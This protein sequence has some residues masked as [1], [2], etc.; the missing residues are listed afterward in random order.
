MTQNA[1]R[2]D[3]PVRNFDGAGCAGCGVE[4]SRKWLYT[5]K[6]RGHLCV[7]IFEALQS[8]VGPVPPQFRSWFCMGKEKK[9]ACRTQQEKSKTMVN[10]WD[11]GELPTYS[12]VRVAGAAI[13]GPMDGAGMTVM[14]QHD[15]FAA[16]IAP[17]GWPGQDEQG[18]QGRRRESGRSRRPAC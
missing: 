18:N 5:N 11:G 4:Q 17:A 13:V 9:S 3:S 2:N 10:E 6:E 7:V 16:W 12:N 8:G 14:L 1:T 15:R